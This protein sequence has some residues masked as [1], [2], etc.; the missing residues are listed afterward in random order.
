MNAR[1]CGIYVSRLKN[2]YGVLWNIQRKKNFKY[3]DWKCNAIKVYEPINGPKIIKAVTNKPPISGDAFIKSLISQIPI[4]IAR[5]TDNKLNLMYNGEDN[6]SQ[7]IQATDCFSLCETIRFGA[8][9]GLIK[10]WHGDIIV[11]TSMGKQSTGKSYLLNH[12]FGTKFDISG[13]RCTDG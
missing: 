9:D 3:L 10:A 7:Y 2:A 12:L 11:V 4:Q 1:T 13:G 8:Y 5:T 6:P